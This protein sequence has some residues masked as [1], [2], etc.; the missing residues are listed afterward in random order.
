[1]TATF[2]LLVGV[3]G[4]GKGTQAKQIVAEY[5]LPHVSTGD[6]FRAMDVQ[7]TPL[8]RQ[9]REIRDAGRLVPDDIT[10]QMVRERLQHPDAANGVLFDG[11]PRTSP[12]AEALDNLL[13]E[14]GAKVD[15][16]L[17]FK[18]DRDV[19]LER[20]ATRFQQEQRGDDTPEKAAK[21]IN[22]YYSITLPQVVEQHYQP[23]GIVA[24]INANQSIA[25]VWAEI[26]AATSG[27]IR[28]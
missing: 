1:V 15:L 28:K 17:L 25:A 16:V 22:D 3:Q 23:L 13:N 20:I 19:A 27:V 6:L 5:G 2:I 18:L 14:F 21:R 8:A 7:D 4:S 24:E 12:Q 9:I 26:L 10:I 11:F